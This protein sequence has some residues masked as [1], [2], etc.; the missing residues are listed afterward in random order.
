M[1]KDLIRK[2]LPIVGI[3]S[4]AAPAYAVTLNPATVTPSGRTVSVPQDAIENSPA[5]EEITIIHFKKGYGHKPQHKPGNGNTGEPTGATCYGFI[6]KG[7]KLTSTE[8]LVYNHADSGLAQNQVESALS[9]SATEWDDST[10]ANIFGSVSYDA[11]SNFDSTPDG[12]NELS[13]GNYPSE[14]VIAVARIW[15]I[16]SG[17][18]SGRYIDQFDIQFDT[19]FAWGTDG[20]QT[21]MD[22]QNIA[23]H[24]I[25]HGIGLADVYEL[26]CSEVTEYGYSDYGETKKS[27]LEQPDITG[28]Q[29][30][31]GN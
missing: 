20:S 4:I 1:L 7:A 19:D 22:L 27:T 3:L 26:V 5:L 9:A 31:Y 30:L 2:I 14:G 15:G 8:N 24:E 25:G 13:F 23:T 17:P 6:S 12:A 18:P 21:L 10:S 16:F 28:L 11:S 29:T